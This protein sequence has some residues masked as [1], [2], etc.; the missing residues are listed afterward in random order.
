MDVCS[1]SISRDSYSSGFFEWTWNIVPAGGVREQ[2]WM[3]NLVEL[4]AEL[5]ASEAGWKLV[6]GHHPVRSNG[7]EHG[8]TPELRRAYSLDLRAQSR[9]N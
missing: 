7:F 6:V 4:E 3:A 1:G 8:D 5:A 2:S 9:A